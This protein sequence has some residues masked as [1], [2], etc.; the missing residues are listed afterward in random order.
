MKS[1]S[2][3]LCI[4]HDQSMHWLGVNGKQISCVRPQFHPFV[5]MFRKQT[6]GRGLS[7]HDWVTCCHVPSSRPMR[8]CRWRQSKSVTRAPRQ[9]AIRGKIEQPDRRR[10]FFRWPRDPKRCPGSSPQVP[11]GGRAPRRGAKADRHCDSPW[12]ALLKVISSSGCRLVLPSRARIRDSLTSEEHHHG[13]FVQKSADDC[14]RRPK[15]GH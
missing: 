7:E 11:G 5:L 3:S 6:R 8:C 12:P 2:N 13:L 14:F 9:I 4:C 1:S 10:A 15:T